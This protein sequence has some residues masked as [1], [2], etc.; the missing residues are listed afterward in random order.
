M[1]ILLINHYAGS[2]ELGMEFRPYYLAKEWQ[3]MGHQVLIIGAT[4]S[5]LRKKQP[6]SQ[7]FEKIDGIDYYWIKTNEYHGN[8]AKR[9]LSMFGFVVKSCLK[10]KGICRNFKPDVVVASSTYTFDN[11]AARRIAK[12]FS[13]KYIYEIHDLWPLS[14]IELGGMNPRHPFIA[15]LQHAENY[16][17]KHCNAVI[18]ILPNAKE[19]CTAHGLAPDKFFH[20]PN[21][22][23]KED[24]DKP[25][26]LPAAH[27][28]LIEKLKSQ[29]R[30]LVAFAGAHGIANSLPSIIDACASLQEKGVS[31]LLVGTGQEKE[32][33]IQYTQNQG[34]KNIHFLPAINKLSIPT[35]LRQMDVLYV[36]LQRQSL[37]RF[38]ISPN[39]IFDY[40]MAA[41]P[42]IQAIDSGNDLIGEAKCGIT[43][44]PENTSAITEAIV[45]L[46]DLTPEERQKLGENGHQYVLKHHTYNVLAQQFVNAI[47]Y[48]GN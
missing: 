18:S 46:T 2:P 41:K 38:G 32:K 15:M 21:G 3:K 47:N 14:P 6:E 17:Y 12:H 30:F 48:A 5:H 4:Y 22:I 43:V 13:A 26:E 28:Q 31:L 7:G 44:E 19:H 9:V 8:G 34:Y 45:Q 23:V 10:Y 35:F 27:Q 20:V 36:G 11:Y 24:W 29:G 33:L 1:H 37:F 39:K 25:A 40:M 16:A 42:I